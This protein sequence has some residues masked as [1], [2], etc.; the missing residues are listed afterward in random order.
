MDGLWRFL[1]VAVLA[2][3]AAA[4]RVCRR[5][6]AVD[7]RGWVFCPR[8]GSPRRESAKAA[9]AGAAPPLTGGP[10]PV[11]PSELLRRGWCR[12]AALDDCGDEVLPTDGTAAK[13]SIWGACDKAFEPHS[14][15]WRAFRK[16]LDDILSER[17]GLSRSMNLTRTRQGTMPRCWQLRVRPSAAPGWPAKA[18]AAQPM[19]WPRAEPRSRYAG[20][21]LR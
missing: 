20:S 1:P 21:L 12:E 3:V 10:I 5:C 11:L 16:H 8:C 19:G 4:R 6:G 9:K 7:R 13:W 17:S 14:H 18:G 15:L 2:A